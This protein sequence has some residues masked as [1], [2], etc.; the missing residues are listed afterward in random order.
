MN[1]KEQ[2]DL[3]IKVEKAKEQIARLRKQQADLERE[4]TELEELTNREEEWYRGKKEC[5]ESLQKAIAVLES[6]DADLNRMIMLVRNTR[7][8]FSAILDQIHAV[9]E[10]RWT[11]GTLREDLGKSLLVIQKARNELSAARGR[12]PALEGKRARVVGG[13]AE[14]PFAE[15]GWGIKDL[16]AGDLVR[17]GFWL[18]LPAALMVIVVMVVF[19]ML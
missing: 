5:A 1:I 14:P 9:R 8:G 2:E 16:T 18:A 15:A 13:G 12:I 19:S 17:I 6:Q 11:P 7:E 10:E 4:K 3:L